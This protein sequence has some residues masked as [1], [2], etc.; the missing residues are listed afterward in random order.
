M[1]AS[2]RKQLEAKEYTSKLNLGDTY[3]IV[4]REGSI[5]S[6]TW[7]DDTV[8]NQRL[9][10]G[11][12]FRTKEEAE[13]E[14]ARRK[15][16]KKLKDLAGG[17]VPNW[18]DTVQYKWYVYYSFKGEEFY[19]N[20]CSYLNTPMQIYFPTREAAQHAIDVLGDELDVLL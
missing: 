18:R 9:E 3:W 2:V 20:G 5:A 11:N 6:Q 19:V 12:V 15:V 17:F 14:V 8:D 1:L 4:G 10:V 16:M 13:K 7:S